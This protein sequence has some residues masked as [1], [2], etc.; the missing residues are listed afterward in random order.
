MR[1]PLRPN[2]PAF[3]MCDILMG[4]VVSILPIFLG[5]PKNQKVSFL[6]AEIYVRSS[7]EASRQFHNWCS[8]WHCICINPAVDVGVVDRLHSAPP[9][10]HPYRPLSQVRHPA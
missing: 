8:A 1:R 5:Y 2:Y 9:S 10:L 6:M 3:G 7:D 4:L